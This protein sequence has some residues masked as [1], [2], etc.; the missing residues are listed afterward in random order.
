MTYYND[1]RQVTGDSVGVGTMR[2][3]DAVPAVDSRLPTPLYHQIYLILREQIADGSA[4]ADATLPGEQE[5]TRLYGVSR[6][7][8]KR[9]L[10]EL[11][12]EG[13]VVR[14][15]GRGTRVRAMPPVPPLHASVEGLLENLFA[16]GLKTE[17]ALLDF[18][19]VPASAETANALDCTAGRIVQRA[20]RVR[21]IGGE[22]FSHLVT[23]VPEAVGRTYTRR[24][25]AAKPLLALLER[26][27]VR[28]SRA[29]QVISAKLA[30][31]QVAPHLGVEIGSAL[32]KITRIVRDQND[33]PVEYITGLYRP[34]RY[35]YAMTLSR[36]QERRGNVWSVDLP[37]AK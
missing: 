27:G 11:A 14:E 7:T 37:R 30:D 32:L 21:S 2:H 18:G 24:D 34:D 16:M 5:L 25:L 10:D 36:V 29:E 13:L 9:A 12:A 35:Q 23:F 1:I 17:V 33:R 19:Y 22:P 6:I 8:A 15:R 4:V 20:R 26:S 28:V 31:A 3:L